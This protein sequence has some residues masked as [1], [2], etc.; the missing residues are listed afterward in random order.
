MVSYSFAPASFHRGSLAKQKSDVTAAMLAKAGIANAGR[1]LDIGCGAGQTLRLVEELN[2]QAMLLGIDPDEEACRSGRQG[3]QR[4]HFVQGEGEHLPI[5]D[6]SVHFAICRV[7]IN[8]MHQATAL[9]EM[10]RVL[11]P[12][13]R[14]VISFHAFG[15]ALRELLCP[16]KHGIRQRLGYLKDFVAGL[17]LHLVGYQGNRRT[18]WGRSVPYTACSRLRRQLREVDF[19]VTWLRCEGHFLG[20]GTV[21]WAIIS[22]KQPCRPAKP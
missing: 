16:P 8:Y 12:G 7:A 1:I 20:W 17:V 21:Q 9:R 2:N 19:E 18:F 5:A 15:Y 10:A 4:I 11:A 3:N 14:I 22:R 13:G 6:R